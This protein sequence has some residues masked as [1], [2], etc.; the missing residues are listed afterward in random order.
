[1]SIFLSSGLVGAGLLVALLAFAIVRQSMKQRSATTPAGSTSTTTTATATS[2]K[3]W[4]SSNPQKWM[5]PA[6]L[7]V[8]A[9]IIWWSDEIMLWFSSSNWATN[10]PDPDLKMLAALA[11]IAIAALIGT[12]LLGK[13]TQAILTI[14]LIPLLLVGVIGFV[15]IQIGTGINNRLSEPS[16][17][18]QMVEFR[19]TNQAN[20][21]GRNQTV[22]VGPLEKWTLNTGNV[23]GSPLNPNGYWACA[24]SNLSILQGRV[25]KSRNT[26]YN[27]YEYE[28]TEAARVRLV[29][30][31]ITSVMV[32]YTYKLGRPGRTSPC[33]QE[34]L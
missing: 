19:S 4:R 14:P 5:W 29:Q 2:W 27:Q 13:V 22:I 28:F 17:R 24:T 7:I 11:L 10:L 31:G 33:D 21:L 18:R 9:I 34:V 3:Q 6:I 8:I 12:S 1:M 16:E 30:E 20:A 23:T 25:F 32:T 26:G 15:L